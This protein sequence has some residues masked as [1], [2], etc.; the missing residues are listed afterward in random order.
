LLVEAGEN[1]RGLGDDCG[2]R[3]SSTFPEALRRTGGTE[4]SFPRVSLTVSASRG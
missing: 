1:E 3:C 4:E 2:A